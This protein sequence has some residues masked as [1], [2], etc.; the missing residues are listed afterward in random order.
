MVLQDSEAEESLRAIL[1][2]SP[3]KAVTR[4]QTQS[5]RQQGLTLKVAAPRF[6]PSSKPAFQYPNINIPESLPRPAPLVIPPSPPDFMFG[7]P[8]GTHGPT[9]GR[10]YKSSPSTTRGGSSPMCLRER[11]PWNFDESE[12][13]EQKKARKAKLRCSAAESSQIAFLPQSSPNMSELAVKNPSPTLSGPKLSLFSLYS[14]QTSDYELTHAG[15]NLEATKDQEA[16]LRHKG[17]MAAKL[18]KVVASS[19]IPSVPRPP[20]SGRRTVSWADQT[21]NKHS[22]H[23][24]LALELGLAIQQTTHH[25]QEAQLLTEPY[26]ELNKSINSSNSMF[27]LS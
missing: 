13:H 22:D 26:S 16:P 9:A 23:L 18:D 17:R 19:T 1:A 6:K 3:P 21:A 7:P 2:R 11:M 27:S 20:V 10:V 25:L 5:L 24:S 8:F 14:E 12:P 15:D 4:S